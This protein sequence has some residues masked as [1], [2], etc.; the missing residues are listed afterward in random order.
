MTHQA[1]LFDLADLIHSYWEVDGEFP[2]SRE[3]ELPR[4]DVSIIVNLA[5]RHAIADR[6][7]HQQTFETAWITGLQSTA[8]VTECGGRAWLC[9]VRLTPEGASRVLGPE[10]AALAGAFWALDEFV[11]A[12]ARR[13]VGD[14]RSGRTVGERLSVLDAFVRRRVVSA[15]PV[16]ASLAWAAAGIRAGNVPIKALADQIGWSRTY[17][18]A[19]FVATFGI[20]PVTYRRLRRFDRAIRALGPERDCARLTELAHALG[21]SDQAHF[22]RDFRAIAGVPASAYMRG[23]HNAVDYGFSAET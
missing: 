21:Y 13:L 15:D 9:G 8:F 4:G 1:P 11:G 16:P 14:V 12:E 19:R 5:G 3:R 10:V 18:H 2:P 20:A 17:L 22:A 6:A 23:Q 7:V